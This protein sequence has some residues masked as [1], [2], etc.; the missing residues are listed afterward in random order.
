[1]PAG[2]VIGTIEITAP[3]IA[4]KIPGIR[5]WII[6]ICQCGTILASV[7]LWQLPRESKGGLLFSCYILASFGGGYAVLMSLQMANTAGYTKRSV[8]SS[9]I[10]VGYC[11]GWWLVSSVVGNST[12]DCQ[13]RQFSRSVTL[14]TRRRS[15]IW[16]RFC[17]SLGN[18]HRCCSTS[19]R[20]SLCVHL[21]E[22]APRQSRNYGRIRQRF[23]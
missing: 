11:L 7:L 8:T 12:S 22:R 5:T 20:L 13:F 19:R 10:F 18:F 3:Y 6:V 16:S 15:R 9:G 23:R 21:G 17:S 4:Y 14:Q 1:M 2:A